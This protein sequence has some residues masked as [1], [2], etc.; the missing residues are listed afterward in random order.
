VT[1]FASGSGTV[2]SD[3]LHAIVKLSL[4]WIRVTTRAVQILPVID[5]C[6]FGLELNCLF[7]AFGARYGNVPARQH[8]MSL[9]VLCK[10][11]RGRLVSIQ[12]VAALASVEVRRR[13]EL[14]CMLVRVAVCATFKPEL[15]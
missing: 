9:L 5:H 11:E 14:P 12:S 6:G 7:V 4:V 3:L 1:S 15:K 13:S 2:R 10:A 8:K